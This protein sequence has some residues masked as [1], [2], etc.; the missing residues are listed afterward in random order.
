M[1]KSADEKVRIARRLFELCVDGYG[2][3]PE[4]LLFD[5]LTFT[6]CTGNE[7]DR[8]LGLETLEAIKR[9]SAEL[10]EASTL[11]GLS[12]ISFG[13][14]PA[15]RHVLNSVFMHHAQE[16]GLTAAILHPGRIEPLHR[17]DPQALRVAEDL[18]FD[19]RKQDYEPSATTPVPTI[20]GNAC[21]GASSKANAMA[22]RRIWNSPAKKKNPW[23]SSIRTCWAAWQR[24]AS[25]SEPA[26]C[27]CP[28]CSSRRKP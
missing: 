8:R 25:Y 21:V 26:T 17:I 18:I 16:A 9:L 28:L 7:D 15:A 27:N 22:W 6:I 5:V 4:D 20:S 11:L 12:N 10:P 19:R 24:W 3:R 14:R 2:M 1:A 13:L 23:P